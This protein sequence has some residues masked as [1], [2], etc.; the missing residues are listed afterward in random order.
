MATQISAQARA[1]N[2]K[3]GDYVAKS[4]I[5]TNPGVVVEK[6]DDGTVVVDTAPEVV[7]EF[8]RYANTSGLTVEQ[9]GQFNAIMDQISQTEDPI[10][11]LQLIDGKIAELRQDPGG[12]KEIMQAL[13][14]QQA[15]LIRKS[16]ELP[17][18]YTERSDKVV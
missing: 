17:R 14:N 10:Q 2:L 9:K 16:G 12:N 11:R 13:R 1:A 18:L 15:K 8:H 3:I 6:K 7:A 5:Y 4:G